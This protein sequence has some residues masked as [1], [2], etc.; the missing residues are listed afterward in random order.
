MAMTEKERTVFQK[1]LKTWGGEA[2]VLC[3]LE[4]MAELQDALCKHKRGRRTLED[5]AEEI[6][7]VEIMLDQ[8]KLLFH[9]EKEA[10]AQRARKIARVEE[11]LNHSVKE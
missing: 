6:A 5:I 7:D 11:R 4:E 8:M 1:V 9:I 3:L 10:E 2:Q